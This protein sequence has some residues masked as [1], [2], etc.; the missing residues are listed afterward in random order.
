MMQGQTVALILGAVAFSAT[1]QIFL[2]SG[3]QQLAGLDGI[4][5]LLA[6][7]RHVH[8]LSGLLAW[9]LSTVCWLYV[10]RVEPL[11]KGYLLSSLTYVL[12]PLASVYVFGEQIRRPHAVAMVL[13]MAGVAL[14][15]YVD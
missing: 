6:A 11:S 3:A 9:A 4:G 14:L 13:I 5:F 7:G 15:L 12:I 8:V 2:K 10:L 1:G